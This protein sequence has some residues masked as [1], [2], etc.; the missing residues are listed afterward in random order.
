M[1]STEAE[2]RLRTTSDQKMTKSKKRKDRM[3]A[4]QSWRGWAGHRQRINKK[5]T[6]KSRPN[7]RPQDDGAHTKTIPAAS[8]TPYWLFS[9]ICPVPHHHLSLLSQ[10]RAITPY[11]QP[12]HQTSTG[13]YAFIQ[14]RRLLHQL[15]LPFA[16][17]GF[18]WC[19]C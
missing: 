15:G 1:A 5:N 18:A 19:C 3:A 16:V 7:R 8:A 12:H 11:S 14:D 9:T 2:N 17:L 4:V 10:S 13:H 6:I